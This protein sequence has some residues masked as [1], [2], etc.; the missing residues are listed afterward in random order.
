MPTEP[1]LISKLS[2]IHEIQLKLKQNEAVPGAKAS[3]DCSIGSV[4]VFVSPR[5]VHVLME[6]LRG[7][8]SPGR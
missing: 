2:G 5:Q 6:L 1:I 3:L 8:T 4:V 7:F